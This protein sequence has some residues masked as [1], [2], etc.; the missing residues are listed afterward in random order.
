M[1]RLDLSTIKTN[2]TLNT[3]GILSEYDKLEN[4]NASFFIAID[5]NILEGIKSNKNI[6]SNQYASSSILNIFHYFYNIEI[7][8]TVEI[9]KKKDSKEKCV[10]EEKEKCQKCN[11]YILLNCLIYN[12]GC[13]ISL[14]ELDN[15]ICLSCDKIEYC[16][17]YFW[18]K[19]NI[20]CYSCD[21]L[22][23]IN[24]N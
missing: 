15:K 5:E 1:K 24:A 18:D 23:Y 17:D 16:W 8:I 19:N 10:I 7:D 22:Y 21:S 20:K 11:P 12:E 14:I 2:Y 6:I 9:E 4:L 13:Y 3:K